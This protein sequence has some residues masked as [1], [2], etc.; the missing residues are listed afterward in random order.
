MR[1]VLEGYRIGFV[2]SARATETRASDPTREYYRKMRTLTGVIQVCAW[3]PGVLL[4]A[5]NPVWLQFVCHKLL[6]L[7]TPYLLLL[8]GIGV[9]G[10]LIER[11]SFGS[12]GGIAT[13]A[14][15]GLLI[16]GSRGGVW[17]GA[18]EALLLLAAVFM[19]TLNGLRGEWDVWQR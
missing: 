9:L 11:R 2:R 17:R 10:T 15:M 3:L 5:R 13:A 16:L 19:A 4:P 12:R 7:A 18:R 14:G 1:L 6:R 8:G